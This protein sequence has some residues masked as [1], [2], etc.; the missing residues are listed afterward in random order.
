MGPSARPSGPAA[1]PIP[2]KLPDLTYTLGH[3]GTGHW[4]LGTG[5]WAGH[6]RQQV[7]EEERQ[8]LQSAID[9][10]LG[11]QAG[12][13]DGASVCPAMGLWVVP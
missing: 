5:H 12:P 8:E 9:Q 6:C 10:W 3:W 13:S 7:M 11:P 1:P 4:A 2:I